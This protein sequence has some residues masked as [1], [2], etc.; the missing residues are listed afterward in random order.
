M[1]TMRRKEV[2]WNIQ[3][4]ERELEMKS[5]DEEAMTRHQKQRPACTVDIHHILQRIEEPLH[6]A[7]LAVAD[8]KE[9][10]LLIK[11]REDGEKGHAE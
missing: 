9:R 5:T 1:R 3:Q 7:Q 2:I 6:S 8:S 4:N 11:D 10:V